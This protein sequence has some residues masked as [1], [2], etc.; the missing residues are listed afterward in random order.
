MKLEDRENENMNNTKAGASSSIF[1][2]IAYEKRKN[3]VKLID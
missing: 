3:V 2:R 1:S